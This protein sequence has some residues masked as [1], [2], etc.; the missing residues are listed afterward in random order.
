MEQKFKSF[1]RDQRTRWTLTA[2]AVTAVAAYGYGM[3]NN[4]VNYDAAYNI[5]L[6]SG[7]ENSGRWTLGLLS[8]L[9][10]QLHIGYSLPFFNI[11]ISLLML[12]L[13]AV[14]LC[15]IL[16][17]TSRRACVLV[18][19]VLLSFPAV[20]SMTFFA[21][22]IQYYAFAFLLITAACLLVERRQTLL[23][24]LLYSLLLAFS[25]GV[26][27]AFYPF[28]IMLAV[29]AVLV[30]CLKPESRPQAVL[31]KGL[32]YVAAILLSYFWYRLGLKATLAIS[33]QKLTAYQGINQMGHIDLRSLP[34]ML[35]D[36][37][38]HFFLLPA[39][40]YLSLSA[41]PI[42]K[43]CIAL[44]LLGSAMMIA[45]GWREK[46]PR[47]WA[48]LAVLLLIAL[49]ISSNLIILMVPYGTTY[50]L[51]GMGLISLFLLPILLWEKLQFPKPRL[52]RF[53]GTALA[54]V[55]LLSSLEYVYL[56]NGC[57]R[58]LE[59]HN[60]Q[61]EN[62]YTTLITRVK[63]LDGYDESFPV[64]YAGSVIHDDSY[65]DLWSETIFNYGG[66]RQFD[67][68]DP[69]NNGFN[70]YSRDRFVRT[71]LGYSIH[72]IN[73]NEAQKY[74]SVLNEMRSYPNDDSIRIT[75][76]IVLV[77]FD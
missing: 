28:A 59:W 33:G 12:S 40:D 67:S 41:E 66:M 57:Y 62:Y 39:R 77:K 47:K 43:I 2:A 9:A 15:R 10:E 73:A 7:G 72:P 6:Y 24:Y 56:S 1:F 68:Q 11:L 18:G 34:G 22:T 61:T 44:L 36:M 17:L 60:I 52:R 38:L 69:A 32:L 49:P 29:L 19:I 4:I 74:E 25:V 54:A 35:K 70:E 3:L 27:Q 23:S 30:D 31:K 50:T 51:M 16:E 64:V 20:A 71:F 76:G 55:L 42:T 21:Y 53:F 45:L 14:L 48:E 46:N 26:Y 13:A 75:D 65:Y 37:Y 63:S 8:R 58:A 5:P